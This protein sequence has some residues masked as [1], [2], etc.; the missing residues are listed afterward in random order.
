MNGF[1]NILKPPGMTSHDIVSW[2]RRMLGIK[3]IGHGGTLDPDAA[4]VLVVAIGQATRL[5]EYLLD[6]PKSYRCE[7][8]LGVVTDTQDLSGEVLE[9]RQ[10]PSDY[11]TQFTNI[12][13]DFTGEI[14]QVPPMVSAVHHNGK[15]LYELAR[16]GIVVE[17]KPRIVNIY[18]IDII[19]DGENNKAPRILFDVH[20]SKGTYIRTLCHD[21]GKALGFGGTM[22]YLLRTSSY[23]FTIDKSWTLEEISLALKEG[24]SS[25]LQPYKY[26]LQGM[27]TVTI[28]AEAEKR[29]LNGVAIPKKDLVNIKGIIKNSEPLCIYNERGSLLATGVMEQKEGVSVIKM[30]KVFKNEG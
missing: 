23:P 30:C 6:N 27:P 3:R 9:V 19:D 12:V 17:R 25:F 10:V 2:L 29:V 11:K 22:S 21:I 14:S 15:R 1:I 8:L 7:I 24:E 5:L 20:C 26:A 13:K 16:K 28:R 18:S 4:G